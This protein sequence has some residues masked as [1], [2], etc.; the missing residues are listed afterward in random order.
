MTVKELI[1][2][3]NQA[4]PDE[5]VYVTQT[6]YDGNKE[7]TRLDDVIVYLT[8]EGITISDDIT[9]EF[10]DMEYTEIYLATGDKT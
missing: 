10:A 9:M 1:A 6:Y 8:N 3:L 5:T 2:I 7:I 4:N